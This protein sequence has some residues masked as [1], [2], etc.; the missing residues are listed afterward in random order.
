MY[1]VT[2][3]EQACK[4]N[5][6]YHILALK[7]DIRATSAVCSVV[8]IA[9]ISLLQQHI[10]EL[11]RIK[12]E[13]IKIEPRGSNFGVVYRVYR[14][15]RYCC[16]SFERVTAAATGYMCQGA[17]NT[18]AVAAVVCYA[19]PQ[20]LPCHVQQQQQQQRIYL[21]TC[22]YIRVLLPSCHM[23]VLC[24]Y[25]HIHLHSSSIVVVLHTHNH[26]YHISI[27]AIQQ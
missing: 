7:S 25:V 5:H 14:A 27:L 11:L 23:F 2:S 1:H 10:Y 13:T 21:A 26:I 22:W 17:Y 3:G 6:P 20:H 12:E 8:Y 9:S 24:E 15:Y 4:G 19:V 16:S 18:T